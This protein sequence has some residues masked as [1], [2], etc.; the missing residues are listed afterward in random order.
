MTYELTTEQMLKEL[1]ITFPSLR[2]RPLSE[3]GN[4][5]VGMPGVWTGADG[6]LMPDGEQIFNTISNGGEAP[7]WNPPTHEAFEAWLANKGWGWENY[8]GGTIFLLPNSS[9]D[10][11]DAQFQE[12]QAAVS[13]SAAGAYDPAADPCPF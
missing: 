4:S 8:D 2:K 6:D 3:F 10:F 5:Y 13:K 1:S 11:L 12:Y 9:Y 7:Y